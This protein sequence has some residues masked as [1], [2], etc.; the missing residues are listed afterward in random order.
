MLLDFFTNLRK[1]SVPVTVREYLTLIEGLSQGLAQDSVE[2]FYGLARTCLIK[3]ERHLDAFDRVFGASFKGLEAPSAALDPEDIPEDWLRSLGEKY[4][5]EEE[6]AAIRKLGWD[7]LM[8]TLRERLRDQKE[9]HQGGSKWIGTGGTSPFG[10]DG[11]HPE[12]VRI[13]QAGNRHFRAAKVWDERRFKD[14]T[15][16]AG[17]GTRNVQL[18]LRRLRRFA[19]TG[20][21]EELDLDATIQGTAAQGF[22]DLKLRPERRNNVKLLIFFDIGGSMDA[23]IAE[24][25]TLFAAARSEFRHL[26]TFYFHNCIYD[27]VW[28]SNARDRAH[29]ISTYDLIHTYAS[30]YRVVFVGDAAMS[31]YE[32]TTP[33]GAVDHWNEE[34]GA[35]WMQRIVSAYRRIAWLNPV[36]QDEWI[37]SPSAGLMRRLVAGRMYPLTLGGLDDAMRALSRS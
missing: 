21:A 7:Q 9:R 28:T 10:A 11:Y 5:S 8:E 6:R 16:E 32:I 13:G 37:Y 20:A 24:A 31:P 27:H 29:K 26:H 15:G 18:A 34:P 3:D 35:V 22:L 30:D 17:I 1:A 4:L 2:T 23:H 19:R 14:L 36:P 12:G 33:G 25:E